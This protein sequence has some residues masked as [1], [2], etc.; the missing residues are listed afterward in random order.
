MLDINTYIVDG[1]VR[2]E[3]IAMDVRDG[4]LSDSDITALVS[5]D[6]IVSGFI[7]DTFPDKCQ[8]SQWNQQYLEELFYASTDEAFNEDY[9]R[10]LHVVGRYVRDKKSQKVKAG[11]VIGVII[12]ALAAIAITMVVMNKNANPS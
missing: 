7:G 2:R 6:R 5:D 12:V 9:L 8:S 4:V 3:S 1:K 11:I 10:Y